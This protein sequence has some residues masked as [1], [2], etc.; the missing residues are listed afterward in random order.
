MD[1][2][3]AVKKLWLKEPG[4]RKV[5]NPDDLLEVFKNGVISIVT[6]PS[7]NDASYMERF[8]SDH[9]FLLTDH[10]LGVKEENLTYQIAFDRMIREIKDIGRDPD[11]A[12]HDAKVTLNDNGI[13]GHE[14]SDKKL[15]ADYDAW[16]DKEKYGDDEDD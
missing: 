9:G 11:D 1:F 14:E 12:M 7:S 3:T 4:S 16:E 5:L 8:L 2:E 10:E 15:S 6:R 13:M